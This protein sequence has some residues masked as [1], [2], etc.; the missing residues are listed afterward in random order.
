M[1]EL[2]LS[3]S[4]PKQNILS[5]SC[6]LQ[7]WLK[8]CAETEW[9]SSL[10]LSLWHSMAWHLAASETEEAL[11]LNVLY[12]GCTWDALEMHLNCTWEVL[13][14]YLRCTWNASHSAPKIFGQEILWQLNLK[15]CKCSFAAN[16]VRATAIRRKIDKTIWGLYLMITCSKGLSVE[17]LAFGAAKYGEMP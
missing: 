6:F 9:L 1:S 8:Q 12:L 11:V 14:M 13:E 4:L 5:W 16:I 2:I 17:T 10:K 15:N 3:D 7:S